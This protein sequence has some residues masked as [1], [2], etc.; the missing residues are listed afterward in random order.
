MEEI[1]FK[2]NRVADIRAIC[3]IGLKGQLGLKGEM[4]WEGN[5]VVW[6]WRVMC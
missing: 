1:R 6:C 2:E 3:A 5:K 4:P